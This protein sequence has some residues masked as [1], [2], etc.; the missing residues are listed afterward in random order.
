MSQ[1]VEKARVKSGEPLPRQQEAES[2]D[3]IT[4][5]CQLFTF[6]VFCQVYTVINKI[7]A[8]LTSVCMVSRSGPTVAPAAPPPMVF[9]VFPNMFAAQIPAS[10]KA[11]EVHQSDTCMGD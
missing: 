9:A 5:K 3:P 1:Q 10:S 7:T 4:K 8:N 6:T 2:Q 11:T